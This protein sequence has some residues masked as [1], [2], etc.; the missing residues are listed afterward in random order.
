MARGN[1]KWKKYN[2]KSSSNDTQNLQVE[3]LIQLCQS[4]LYPLAKVS[5]S[6]LM[7]CVSIC[8]LNCLTWTQ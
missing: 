1:E 7:V 6:I 8:I 3:Q 4:L 5:I 2:N